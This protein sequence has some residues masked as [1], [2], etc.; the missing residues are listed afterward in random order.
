MKGGHGQPEFGK[1]S[2]HKI[3]YMRITLAAHSDRE[4]IHSINGDIMTLLTDQDVSEGDEIVSP[5]KSTSTHYALFHVDEIKEKRAPMG[6]WV[7][8]PPNL[9]KIKFRKEWVAHDKA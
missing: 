1:L 6:D 8:T 5:H 9:Y 2:N 4:D 3:F 7:T